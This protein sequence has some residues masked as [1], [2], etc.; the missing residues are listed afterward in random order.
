MKKQTLVLAATAL[1][2]AGGALWA[3]QNQKPL[4]ATAPNREKNGAK[5][6]EI[7]WQPS[8]EA[9]LS[10]AKT[11]GKIVMIDFGAKWCGACKVMDEKTYPD[12]AVIA[13]SRDF[14]MLKVDV[15]EQP[16][17]ANRYGISALPTT[18]WIHGDGKPIAGAVGAL[19]PRDLLAAMREATKRA[20][21]QAK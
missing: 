2:G 17:L 14:V 12:P 16:G 21:K 1:L 5:K 19:G 18:G 11:S 3:A 10:Q 4:D 6:A 8:F 7:D 13:A 15:D 20:Q 9:A